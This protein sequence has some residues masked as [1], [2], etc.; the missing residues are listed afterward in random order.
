MDFGVT[1]SN[2]F[3]LGVIRILCGN[4]SLFLVLSST[5]LYS[6]RVQIFCIAASLCLIL[7]STCFYSGRVIFCIAVSV[8]FGNIFAAALLTFLIPS[9]FS[10]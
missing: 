5:G 9:H 6:G 10:L 3:F 7:S 4:S 8:I 1:I 2:V